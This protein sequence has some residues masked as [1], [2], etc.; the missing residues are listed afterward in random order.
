MRG[1]LLIL[2]ST[3]GCSFVAVYPTPELDE[4]TG[5]KNCASIAPLVADSVGTAVT[6]LGGL[7]LAGGIAAVNSHCNGNAPGP[8]DATNG[9]W[10]PAAI[11]GASLIYGVVA[12]ANCRRQLPREPVTPWPSPASPDRDR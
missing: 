12:E 10:I 4:R 2:A 11:Y 5:V 8:C 3:A 9:W 7:T 1:L 6:L